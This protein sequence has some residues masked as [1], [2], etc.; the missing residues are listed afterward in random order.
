MLG[1]EP[2]YGPDGLLIGIS[3]DVGNVVSVPHDLKSSTRTD[4]RHHSVLRVEAQRSALEPGV[5]IGVGDV[6][7]SRRER[8]VHS[9]LPP[10][11]SV[12]GDAERPGRDDVQRDNRCVTRRP[13][14]RGGGLHEA[15]RHKHHGRANNRR[16]ALRPSRTSAHAKSTGLSHA[17]PS[18]EFACFGP[19]NVAPD[20]PGRHTCALIPITPVQNAK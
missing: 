8:V 13:R 6:S 12:A 7:P 17:S 9:R 14:H 18:P 2:T 11:V 4:R 5:D 19:A 15:G 20:V 10:D 3:D 16:A 1:A